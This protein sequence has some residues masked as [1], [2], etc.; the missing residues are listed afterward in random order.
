M[1]ESPSLV[2]MLLQHRDG[3]FGLVLAL[4]R[5]REAAEEIF[6]EVGLAIVEEAGRGTRVENFLPWAHEIIRRR[7]AEHYRK[8][9]R[10]PERRDPESMDRIVAQSFEEYAADPR[11]LMLR[12]RYLAECLEELPSTQ[13]R[14][15]QRRYRD[16]S[17]IRTIAA[18]LSWSEGAI[19]VGLWK[20]RRR[21]ADCIA[22]KLG[23]H[24]HE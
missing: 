3:L 16:R 2:K 13:R 6:Q 11:E 7:V 9:G 15:I 1:A 14:M 23:S 10:A 22:G 17:S 20:A 12:R 21:L 8:A 5:D 18:W 19:K 4:A 24:G